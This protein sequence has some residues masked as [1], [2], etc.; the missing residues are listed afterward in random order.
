MFTEKHKGFFTRISVSL[1]ICLLVVLA[2]CCPKIANFSPEFGYTGTEVTITG[3][4]FRNTSSE[5]IVKFSDVPVPT[6]DIPY[7]STTMIKAKVPVGAQ[8]GPISVSNQYC[9]GTSE[10][11]FIVFPTVVPK[12]DLIP[13]ALLFDSNNILNVTLRNE[14]VG[15]VPANVGHLAIFIE[16]RLADYISFQSLSDQS[17]RRPGLSQTIPTN[18]RISGSNRRIA[19]FVDPNNAIEE[20]NEFQNTLSRT[21]TPPAINGPDLIINTIKVT[22]ENELG[23]SVKNIGSADSPSGQV[24]RLKIFVNDHLFRDLTK[25]LPSLNAQGGTVIVTVT[26]EPPATIS[27]SYRVRA[28]LNTPHLNDETD[29]T[30]NERTEI[31]PAHRFF[32]PYGELLLAP[33][34]RRNIIW[35][36]TRDY[37]SVV[38]DYA[39]W[40]NSQ[41]TDL[42]NM[43]LRI[44]R[45]E[46]HTLLVAPPRIT[47]F[48]NISA[49][50]AWRIY[51]SHVAQSLWVEVHKVVNWHLAD[52]SDE[53][54]AYLLDSRKLLGYAGGDIYYF[55]K[56]FMGEITAWNPRISYEFLSNLKMIKSSQLETIY[57]LTNW[58]GSHLRHIVSGEQYSELFEYTGPPPADKVLYPL[59]GRFHKTAGCW[60]TTGLYGAVLRSVNIPVERADIMLDDFNHCRPSFPSVD[61][62]MPHGDDPYNLILSPS[63]SVIPASK[64]F[65]SL[66]EMN[67]RFINPTVDCNGSTCNTAGEQASYNAGKHHWQLAYDYMAD[68]ILYDYA[69]Y[70]S[71]HLNDS[72]RGPRIGVDF[73]P[74]LYAKPYFNNTERA[75]MVEAVGNKIWEI[76]GGDLETG[77]NIVIERYDRFHTNK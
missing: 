58:M 54:L 5:N 38:Q 15:E 41:K 55:H 36:G 20:S 6:S 49:E 32:E 35:E 3:E 34:I 29:N 76:G 63:G 69:K 44:E 73:P 71:D 31:F 30:N 14:G 12:P 46:L 33:K 45:G 66:S 57:A 37:Q 48:T 60:G 74:V 68:Y 39:S 64:M 23:V 25:T 72:L 22:P 4:G 42:R 67:A 11:N 40:T 77:K 8:T 62:S 65:Y 21:M 52:F 27:G 18:L 1:S 13:K 9:T 19:V 2:G 53:Q 61:R 47:S 16:G 43:I 56:Y 75:A 28:V 26:E 51:L 50:D 7:A 10:R 70:G 17:F 24:V 59:E